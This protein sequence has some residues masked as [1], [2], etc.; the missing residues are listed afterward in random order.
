MCYTLYQ[1]I[2]VRVLVCHQF[3]DQTIIDQENPESIATI[4]HVQD[5]LI[6]SSVTSHIR[7]F[8]FACGKYKVLNEFQAVSQSFQLAYITTGMLINVLRMFR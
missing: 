1:L 3:T 8:S 6:L 7:V 4:Y 5:L 2:M